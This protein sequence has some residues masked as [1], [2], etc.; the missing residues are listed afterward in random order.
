MLWVASLSKEAAQWADKSSHRLICCQIL[1]FVREWS[2]L[3]AM[4][5]R[6]VRRSGQL[7]HSPLLA[8]EESTKQQ[9]KQSSTKRYARRSFLFCLLLVIIISTGG[10]DIFYVTT[11][12]ILMS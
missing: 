3:T 6:V 1:R 9:R 7:F 12:E 11:N 8:L 5:Q 10:S 4:K 2:G